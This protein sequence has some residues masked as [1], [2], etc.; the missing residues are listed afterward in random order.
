VS[1]MIYVLNTLIVPVDFDKR[2][3]VAVKFR[4]ITVEEAKELLKSE[5]WESAIGHQATAAIL[6]QLLGIEVSVQ[7]KMIF[8]EKGDKGIHFF[9]KQRLPEGVV[10]KE[11]E[12][13]KLDFWLVLSE[14]E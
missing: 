1:K 7:R 5:D 12:L 2:E 11:E 10:L 3:E 8:F 9:L 4:R 6:S 13:R 14:V